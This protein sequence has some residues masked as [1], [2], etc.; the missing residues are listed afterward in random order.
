MIEYKSGDILRENAEA[1]INT[2]NCVGVMG[3]GIALQFKKVFPVEV[4]D[5]AI[6]TLEEHSSWC[7]DN[8][9][10]VTPLIIFNNNKLSNYY[11]IDELVDILN[12]K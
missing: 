5:I 3:R 1:L 6:N 2:V 12:E 4:S 11:S 10:F 7:I 8:K 9:V